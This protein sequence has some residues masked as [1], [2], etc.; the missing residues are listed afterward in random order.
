M[1]LYFEKGIPNGHEIL[2]KGLTLSPKFLSISPNIGSM[3]GTLLTITAP[4]IGK[5]N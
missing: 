3:G 2:D 5:L 4:G 1:K